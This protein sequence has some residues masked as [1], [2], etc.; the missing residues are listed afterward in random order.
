MT[1]F[2]FH[3]NKQASQRAGF[4]QISVHIKK[5]CHIV[6][7]LVCSVPIYGYTSKR[8]PRFVMKGK[9]KNFEIKN[10]IAIIT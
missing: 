8:Q 1:P 3:Y 9:C 5:T 2:F 6:D 4:C 10:G 7:N